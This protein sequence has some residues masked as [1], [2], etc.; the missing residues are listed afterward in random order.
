MCILLSK[1][2][3]EFHLHIIRIGRSE[4][5]ATISYIVDDLKFWVGSQSHKYGCLCATNSDRRVRGFGA[6]CGHM[7]KYYKR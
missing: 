3:L 4:V 1:S 5:A 2:Q 7:S 6:T